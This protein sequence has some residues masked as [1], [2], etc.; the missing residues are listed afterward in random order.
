MNE[1]REKLQQLMRSDNHRPL[2]SFRGEVW[3]WSDCAE[4]VSDI[5]NMLDASDI[6]ASVNVGLIA[7]NRPQHAAVI[8][9]MIALDR[10]LTMVH[11]YQSEAAL[12][13]DVKQLRL[14]VVISD[15][16]DC[17]TSLKTEI[18]DQGAL[19]IV[20]PAHRGERCERLGH[21]RHDDN[22]RR[23]TANGFEVLS[24][25][26]TGKPT[27]TT[28]P[29]A[30]VQRALDSILAVGPE[31]AQSAEIVSWPFGTIGGLCQIVT[32][33]VLTRP[34]T[35]LEKFSL[36]EWLSAIDSYQPLVLFVQ[37]TVLR[38]VL[39]ADVDKERLASLQ[40]ISG[41]AGPLEPELQK[42]FEERYGIPLLWAYGATEFCGT[43][44][45]WT[46]DLRKQ[47]G[48]SKAG[49]AGKPIQ[50]VD[51]RIIDVDN[52]EVLGHGETGWLEAKVR[53]LSDDWVRTTDL[54]ELD[55]DGFIFIKGRG[56]G[57]I[58][59]GGFKILPEQLV[60]SLR[61]HP[62]VLDAAVVGIDDKV[63]G[64]VPVAVLEL[65]K[66]A[67]LT[68]AEIEQFAREKLLSYQIPVQWKI[69]DSL[70]RTS[71]MKV[72]LT[73]ISEMFA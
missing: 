45:S 63:L 62:A 51:V 55:E 34:F 30:V 32:A 9:G 49:S 37:P 54:A 20:L 26:T 23:T 71:T 29:F 66:G 15:A 33:S 16:E 18:G 68:V 5:G 39:D 11:V 21:Y 25:G 17:S 44:I 59:R 10:R 64:Q 2:L 27:R 31:V 19:G 60:E 57:A 46:I 6:E 70:P 50:G 65:A 4:I 24:S 53:G 40:V 38:M 61:E 12:A 3:L 8:L 69:V 13:E 41:G 47:F 7:R 58:N 1:I 28:M 36:E 52:G 72:K 48:L 73:E 56:D 35:L 22:H 14:G 67:S 43:I 42:R